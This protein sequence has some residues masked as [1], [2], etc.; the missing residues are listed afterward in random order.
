MRLVKHFNWVLCK[1][2]YLK[3]KK[4]IHVGIESDFFLAPCG[5]PYVSKKNG[6]IFF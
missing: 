2:Y 4:N 5:D 3:G 1:Q 6:L